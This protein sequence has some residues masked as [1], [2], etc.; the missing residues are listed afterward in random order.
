MNDPTSAPA[1]TVRTAIDDDMM[2][3]IGLARRF[4]ETRATWRQ[5][6]EVVN[7]TERALRKAFHEPRDADVVFIAENRNGERLG[8]AYVVTHHDFFTGEEHGH[9]SEIATVTDGSGAGSVLMDAAEAWSR[10][11]GFR[12]LSLNVNDTNDQAHQFYSRRD[13]RP[14]YRHLAKMLQ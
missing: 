4:G 7:G 11:R 1:P 10:R 6:D 12:Y 2:F 5:L 3:V 14:E 9:V 13:Y 8:F